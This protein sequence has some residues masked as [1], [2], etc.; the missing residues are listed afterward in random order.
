MTTLDMRPTLIPT[1]D[2]STLS[3]QVFFTKGRDLTG[4]TKPLRRKASLTQDR[5]KIMKNPLLEKRVI[6]PRTAG[7]RNAQNPKH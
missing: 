4:F 1:L 2:A 6:L 5:H 3:T 7:I